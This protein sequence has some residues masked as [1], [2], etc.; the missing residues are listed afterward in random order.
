VQEDALDPESLERFLV[1]RLPDSAADP[2][3]G[4]RERIGASGREGV[5]ALRPL[6]R[7]LQLVV[8]VDAAVVDPWVE[9]RQ[10]EDPAGA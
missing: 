10:V 9:E 5:V 3:V 2:V 8:V 1:A 6:A 7:L 4:E